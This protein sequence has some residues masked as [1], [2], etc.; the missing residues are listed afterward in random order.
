MQDIPITWSKALEKL[1][2]EVKWEE[3]KPYK[4]SRKTEYIVY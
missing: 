2:D 4:R 1:E 3:I